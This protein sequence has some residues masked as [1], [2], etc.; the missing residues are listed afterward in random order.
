[1]NEVVDEPVTTEVCVVTLA[2]GPREAAGLFMDHLQRQR[3]EVSAASIDPDGRVR[4]E[5]RTGVG[6]QS[7]WA[8]RARSAGFEGYGDVFLFRVAEVEQLA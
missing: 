4:V 2:D 7:W 8:E 3:Q 6:T 5:L 1:M